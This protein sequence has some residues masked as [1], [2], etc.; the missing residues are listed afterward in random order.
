MNYY[1][2]QM[3][4]SAEKSIDINNTDYTSAIQILLSHQFNSKSNIEDQTLRKYLIDGLTVKCRPHSLIYYHTIISENIIPKLSDII[5]LGSEDVAKVA[6]SIVSFVIISNTAGI[7]VK[8]K[9][10][11]ITILND[12][13]A[14]ESIGLLPQWL[15]QS[16]T[17]NLQHKTKKD[18]DAFVKLL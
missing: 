2:D 3:Q 11:N 15:K 4:E 5:V 17:L 16:I 18:I 7:E 12:K 13:K 10:N 9:K 8:L 6:P 14:F 1:S